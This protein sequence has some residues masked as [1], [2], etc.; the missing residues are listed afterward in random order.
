MVWVLRTIVILGAL[1]GFTS[2]EARASGSNSDYFIQ[3][4]E[5]TGTRNAREE[6]IVRALLGLNAGTDVSLGQ[7]RKSIKRIMAR[8]FYRNVEIYAKPALKSQGVI[9]QVRLSPSA[10]LDAFFIAGVSEKEK[11]VIRQ[12]LAVRIGEP[13]SERFL[14]RIS[15]RAKHI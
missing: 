1:I 9:L 5:I 8:G 11:R 2:I 14:E 6:E 4:I 12:R 7:V 13:V 3:E 15:D 10:Y